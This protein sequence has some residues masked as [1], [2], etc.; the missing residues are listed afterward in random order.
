MD[1]L[2]PGI[3]TEPRKKI[4]GYLLSWIIAFVITGAIFGI[5]ILIQT[6]GK[7]YTWDTK[8]STYL[9]L[10]NAFTI[11]AVIM[12]LMWLLVIVS[13]NGVFDMIGYS[14]K[15]VWT[16]TFHRNVRDTKLPRTF[17]EYREIKRGKPRVNSSYL[18]L[19]AAP[20]LL[21]GLILMIPYYTKFR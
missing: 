21:T 4:K 3:I 16:V 20:Y 12:I 15:L 17:A 7:G 8:P 5:I 2:N 6:G 13:N 18:L 9:I 10:I 14:V 1:D 19:A 11:S